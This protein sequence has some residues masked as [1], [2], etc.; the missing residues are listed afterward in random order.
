MRPTPSHVIASADVDRRIKKLTF[1]ATYNLAFEQVFGKTII[2]QS[3]EV[4]GAYVRSHNLDSI[5]LEGDKYDR[6]GSIT[7]GYHDVRSSRIDAIK[8]L[9]LWETKAEEEKKN[10]DEIEA[11]TQ[12]LNQEITQLVGAIHVCE[13][14][15]SKAT[16]DGA[17][18]V[19]SM[20][21]LQQ[22]EDALKTRIAKLEANL[23][24]Q[25]SAIRNLKAEMSAYEDELK[26]KM[27]QSLSDEEEQQLATLNALVDQTKEELLELSARRVEVSTR[28]SC[29]LPPT[30]R[31]LVAHRSTRYHRD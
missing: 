13:G 14:K 25:Q 3:L 26:T 15:L 16:A 17:P 23:N 27:E 6:K 19:A 31:F 4:A 21:L 2:C 7:G 18:L 29:S 11:T 30:D 10:H 9:K 28:L 1:D 24:L 20:L 5:T 12:R 8:N 22:E